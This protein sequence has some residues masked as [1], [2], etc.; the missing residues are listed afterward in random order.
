MW[1]SFALAALRVDVVDV[2]DDDDESDYYFFTFLL[3]P[4]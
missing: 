1:Q 2:D 3:C 4:V